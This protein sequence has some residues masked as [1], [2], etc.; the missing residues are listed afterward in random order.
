MVT[1]IWK[2][3]N[4]SEVM[5][6]VVLSQGVQNLPKIALPL[7]VLRDEQLLPFPPNFEMASKT[8]KILY[9]SEAIKK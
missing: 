4:F 5:N 6:K 9:F 1:K 8:R 2:I 7:I 3:L